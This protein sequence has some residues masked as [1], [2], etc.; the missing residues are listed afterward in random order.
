[1]SLVWIIRVV[2]VAIESRDGEIII[3]KPNLYYKLYILEPN[4]QKKKKKVIQFTTNHVW[5]TLGDPIE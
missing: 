1:M 4:N 5:A 2:E 3:Y